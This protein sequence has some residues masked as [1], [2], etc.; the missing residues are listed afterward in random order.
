V[1]YLD[2]FHRLMLRRR[3][4]ADHVAEDKAQVGV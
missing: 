1:D 3:R 2:L 4:R